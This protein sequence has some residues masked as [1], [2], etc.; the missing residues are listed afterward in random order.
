MWVSVGEVFTVSAFRYSFFLHI[1]HVS[2]TIRKTWGWT[3]NFFIHSKTGWIIDSKEC[4]RGVRVILLC[5]QK[6]KCSLRFFVHS[7]FD[8]KHLLNYAK[9]VVLRKQDEKVQVLTIQECQLE[10]KKRKITEHR[11][12]AEKNSNIHCLYRLVDRQRKIK[13]PFKRSLTAPSHFF[14][15]NST[16]WYPLLYKRIFSFELKKNNSVKNETQIGSRQANNNRRNSS[17]IGMDGVSTKCDFATKCE[18]CFR[19]LLPKKWF[20]FFNLKTPRIAWECSN[21]MYVFAF[22]KATTDYKPCTV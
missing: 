1:S 8:D 9:K 13:Y 16:T 3:S 14:L 20:L 11:F 19:T 2:L 5:H 21:K 17:S 6:S 15:N 4:Y 10:Q 12:Y 22:D 7:D 18:N